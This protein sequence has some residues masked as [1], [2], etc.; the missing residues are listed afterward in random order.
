MSI[1]DI[2]IAAVTN[3]F[4]IYIVWKFVGLF[5]TERKAGKR[6][7]VIA[8][9]IFYVISFGMFLI[10]HYPIVNIATNLICLFLVTLLYEG[11]IRKKITT[12]VLIYTIN[13]VSDILASFLFFDYKVGQTTPQLFSIVTVLLIQISELIAARLLDNKAK[14]EYTRG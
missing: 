1:H 4:R 14:Q 13:M 8:Y 6:T 7:E 2:L 5:L 3:L 10:F 9:V 11:S 12:T